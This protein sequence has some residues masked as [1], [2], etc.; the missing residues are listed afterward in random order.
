M[1][2]FAKRRLHLERTDDGEGDGWAVHYGPLPRK[3]LIMI[4]SMD[5]GHRVTREK[6]ESSQ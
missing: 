4:L 3:P 6:Y 1:Q 5:H 2:T